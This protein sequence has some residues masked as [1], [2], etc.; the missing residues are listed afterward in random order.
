MT[1][2]IFLNIRLRGSATGGAQKSFEQS[3][4]ERMLLEQKFRMP[5]DAE[6]K[7]VGRGFDRLDDAVGGQSAGNQ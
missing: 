3:P 1:L 2:E 7:P 6:K 5:L 4:V